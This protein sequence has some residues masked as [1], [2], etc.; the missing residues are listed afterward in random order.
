MKN[1]F[2]LI[3][4]ICFGL[5]SCKNHFYSNL[6]DGSY[7]EENLLGT[8][9]LYKKCQYSRVDKSR[10]K[11]NSNVYWKPHKVNHDYVVRFYQPHSEY[12]LVIDKDK[13]YASF[14][15]N[16]IE[17]LVAGWYLVEK[18]EKN[19][20]GFKV[21]RSNMIQTYGDRLDGSFTPLPKIY[22]SA[23][24]IKVGELKQSLTVQDKEVI[25]FIKLNNEYYVD[26]KSHYKN[27]PNANSSI[28]VSCY[29][30]DLVWFK[31]IL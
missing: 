27:N 24:Y 8:Y 29:D 30:A 23:D 22:N 17:D 31:K 1:I 12:F 13:A 2:V 16:L 6:N 3:I 18:I 21:Y 9:Y 7:H 20:N 28:S 26:C 10:C 14:S 25:E 5:S 19:N 4:L 11:I 15:I